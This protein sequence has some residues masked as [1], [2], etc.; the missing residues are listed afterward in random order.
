[1]GNWKNYKRVFLPEDSEAFWTQAIVITAVETCF[2]L[3][4]LQDL[5]EAPTPG[6][7]A[8]QLTPLL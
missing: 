3:V 1:M 7:G 5:S 8:K 4:L 2:I 6:G